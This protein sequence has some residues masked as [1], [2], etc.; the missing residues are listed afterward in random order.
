MKRTGGICTTEE[1]EETAKS[2]RA[3]DEVPT[4]DCSAEM[5]SF[6][7][8]IFPI[9]NN[10]C[11]CDDYKPIR[12]CLQADW[13]H[14][15]QQDS[16]IGHQARCCDDDSKNSCAC[17]DEWH[18]WII[19]KKSRNHHTAV[20]RSCD[21]KSGEVEQEI[22]KGSRDS[23]D[24]IKCCKSFRTEIALNNRAKE[25]ET[26]HVEKQMLKAGMTELKSDESPKLQCACA[27]SGNCGIKRSRC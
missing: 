11:G 27:D 22:D 6:A 14:E 4:S 17:S 23:T 12:Q 13:N 16:C 9:K 21:N 18:I 26:K 7:S 3:I 24:E 2:F 19:R 20:G 5:G 10:T 1:I 8:S 15:E 25:K